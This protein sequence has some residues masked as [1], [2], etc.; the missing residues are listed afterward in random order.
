VAQDYRDGIFS[1][2]NNLIEVIGGTK[3]MT[4]E[5]SVAAARP[6]FDTDGRFGISDARLPAA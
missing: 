1:G 3:P 2:M 6:Q 5:D 4:V